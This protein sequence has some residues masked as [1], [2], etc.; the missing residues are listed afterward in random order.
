MQDVP[1]RKLRSGMKLA[2]RVRGT[3][4]NVL[5]ETGELL[6]T[7]SI[8]RF[9][10]AKVFSVLVFGTSAPDCSLGYNVKERLE[11]L[12]HLF[13][14]HKDNKVMT[15]MEIFLTKHFQKRA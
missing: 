10:N 7:E 3:T 15:K 9:M 14:K 8:R 13:K 12:P 2:C 4:G 5:A 1:I 6:S 11:R